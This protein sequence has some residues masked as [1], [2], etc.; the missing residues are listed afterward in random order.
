MTM[1]TTIGAMTT[2]IRENNIAKGWRSAT[3]GPGGNTL[4]DYIALLHSETAE[5]LEAYRSWKMADATDTERYNAAGLPKPEGVG[6]ELADLLIRLLDTGD[7]FGFTAFDRD[8]EFGDV[9]DLDPHASDPRL[10]ELVTFGDHMAW[11]DRRIDKIW[12]DTRLAPALAL[13]AVVTVARK[14][15]VDLDFEYARKMAYNRTRP[16]RHGGRALSKTN[17]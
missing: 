17:A 6:S 9:A 14:Y 4:G 11:I 3:G 1:P 10:P 15:G 8:M 7:V 2:E 12:T 13:R 5:A 16:F